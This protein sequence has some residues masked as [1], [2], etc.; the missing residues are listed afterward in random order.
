MMI[1]DG[2]GMHADSMAI[3]STTPAYPS[4][5]IV[6]TIKAE[7]ISI[8]LATKQILLRREVGG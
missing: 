1:S 2:S 4:V 3:S 6:A 8:I 7:R 5:E